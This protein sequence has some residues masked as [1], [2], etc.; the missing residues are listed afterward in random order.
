MYCFQ[1]LFLVISFSLKTRV[2]LYLISE[3]KKFKDRCTIKDE[4]FF[5]FFAVQLVH[6]NLTYY[7]IIIIKKKYIFRIRS[8]LTNRY[9]RFNYF[10]NQ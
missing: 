9:I 4:D 1:F 2:N 10:S 3:T 6:A 8:T 5:F 7:N